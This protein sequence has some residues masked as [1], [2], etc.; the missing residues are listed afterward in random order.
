MGTIEANG[1]A[2]TQGGG[3]GGG[4]I[5]LYHYGISTFLGSLQTYG[6]ESAAER[7]GNISLNLGHKDLSM[8]D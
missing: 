2:G 4:R 6:G 1:G 3:G 8:N 5:A 7:G